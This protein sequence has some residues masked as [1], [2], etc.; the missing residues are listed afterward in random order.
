MTE[1]LHWFEKL[2]SSSEGAAL[3]KADQFSSL[4]LDLSKS[5]EG[6]LVMVASVAQ[7]CFAVS[8]P[9]CLSSRILP[10]HKLVSIGFP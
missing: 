9:S 10:L 4:P 8:A 6:K 1:F 7:K 5:K 3:S 2:A